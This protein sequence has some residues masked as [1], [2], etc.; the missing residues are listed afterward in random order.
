[1]CVLRIWLTAVVL[2]LSNWPAVA[3]VLDVDDPSE[4]KIFDSIS[5]TFG[6]RRF[7]Y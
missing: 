7:V 6:S 5:A 2:T 4:S 3:I 1:M